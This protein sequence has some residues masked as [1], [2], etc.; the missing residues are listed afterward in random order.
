M[1]DRDL[2]AVTVSATLVIVDKAD[3]ATVV[4]TF[5]CHP[6]DITRNIGA[7]YRGTA[8]DRAPLIMTYVKKDDETLKANTSVLFK[9]QTDPNTT[10]VKLGGRP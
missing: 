3:K 10:Q 6:G 7:I 4:G 2:K 9:V 1:P 5:N 8:C